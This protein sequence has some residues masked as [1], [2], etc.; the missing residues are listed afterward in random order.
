MVYIPGGMVGPIWGRVP[1]DNR[2][3]LGTQLHALLFYLK[4][5]KQLTEILYS[6]NP[7]PTC[8]ILDRV[9]KQVDALLLLFR[10]LFFIRC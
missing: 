7:A 8:G 1:V 2:L 6:C 5:E 3:E 10:D 4:H 9:L